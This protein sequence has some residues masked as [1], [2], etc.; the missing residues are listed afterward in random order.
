V[1]LRYNLALVQPLKLAVAAIVQKK[2][3]IGS[4]VVKIGKITTATS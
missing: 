2:A 1:L 3:L 4:H